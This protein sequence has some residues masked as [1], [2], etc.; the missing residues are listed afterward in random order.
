M[1]NKSVICDGV[2]GYICDTA[3][4]YAMRIHGAIREFPKKLTESAYADVLETYNT[5]V[6]KEKFIRFYESVK[7][8]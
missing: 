5:D 8:Q 2:N 7:L 6:M 3:E 1:G 4:E